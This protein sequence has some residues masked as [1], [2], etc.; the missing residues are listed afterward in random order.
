MY[1]YGYEALDLLFADS[2]QLLQVLL[3][4]FLLHE[5]ERLVCENSMKELMLN[6]VNSQ[7][8]HK[9]TLAA[10]RCFCSS[11]SIILCSGH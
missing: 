4:E 8:A 7:V 11:H 2:F 3:N 9:E 10:F 1:V 6:M 5:V